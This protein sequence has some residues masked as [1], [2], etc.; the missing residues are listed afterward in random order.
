LGAEIYTLTKEHAMN[1]DLDG[2]IANRLALQHALMTGM[3][4]RVALRWSLEHLDDFRDQVT[5]FH[6]EEHEQERQERDQIYQEIKQELKD[7]MVRWLKLE[8]AQGEIN[9]ADD[10]VDQWATYYEI[11]TEL[12]RKQ[13]LSLEA[14]IKKYLP[15][16]TLPKPL[17][18]KQRD[19]VLDWLEG[20]EDEQ[21]N[22]D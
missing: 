22:P 14:E 10:L 4:F 19:Q 9:L 6:R 12:T 7:R 2:S 3:E 5:D 11:P 20:A 21:D 13:R 16:F 8:G 15:T 17:E 1:D 18:L